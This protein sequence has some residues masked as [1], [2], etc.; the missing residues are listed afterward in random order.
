[1]SE[2]NWR[3][4]VRELVK[5]YKESCKKGNKGN[6]HQRVM[7]KSDIISLEAFVLQLESILSSD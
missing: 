2:D 5:H 4:E 6:V 3:S 7:L 1:M